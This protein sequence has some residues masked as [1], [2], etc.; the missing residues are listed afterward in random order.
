MARARRTWSSALLLLLCSACAVFLFCEYFIYFPVILQCSWPPVGRGAAADSELLR[1]LVLADTHLLGT[2]RGHWFDKLRRSW[3]MERSFQTAL[4]LLQPEVV[5][6]LGDVFDEGKWS[7]AEDWED[8]VRRFQQMFRHPSSTELIVVVGNHDV[9]FHYEMSSLKL[10]RFEK[11]F[12]ANSARMV[13]RKGVNFLLVNSVAMEGDGCT[14]CHA[15]E[16]RLLRLSR[17]LDCSMQKSQSNT[18]RPQCRSAQQLPPS[19]PIILQV[20]A[21]RTFS[22]PV[23][24]KHTHTHFSPVV[25]HYPL[26]RLSDANCTGEDAARLEERHLLFKERYDVLSHAAST[27]L[28]RWFQPRLVLSGHTHSGCEILHDGKHP[29]ISVPSFSWRNRNN[30]SF[31]LGVFSSDYFNLSKCFLPHESTVIAVYAAT[32]VSVALLALLPPVPRDGLKEE[33]RNFSVDLQLGTLKTV[34]E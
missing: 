5:F 7:S 21:R 34:T 23:Y 33:V 8:D 27:K 29:E 25:Q 6:I 15:V 20:S 13:S 18:S 17:D 4:W 11:L 30:P 19:A 1:V 32:G 22:P 2:F 10:Q 24:G 14:I 28:L 26:Y 31:F 3:Q 9:G 12:G 16:K